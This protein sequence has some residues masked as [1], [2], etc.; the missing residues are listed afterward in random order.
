[1]TA[2]WTLAKMRILYLHQYFSTRAGTVGTRSYEFASHLVRNGHRVSMVTG[3]SERSRI[4]DWAENSRGLINRGTVDGIGVVVVNVRYSNQMS[5]PRRMASFIM[6]MLLSM[7]AGLR[8]GR[9]DLVFATSTPLTIGIP[10]YIL[11]RL[12]RVPFVFEIRDLWPAAPIALG[13]ITNSVLIRL[14]ERLERFLY[15]SA[16][17]VI[18]LS[19]DA[20]DVLVR[21]G[22]SEEKLQFI[23][24]CSD[25]DLFTPHMESDFRSQ[26]NLDDRF[27]CLYTGAMGVANGLDII[28]STADLLRDDGVVFVMVGEGREK[29]RLVSVKERLRLDNVLF[30]DPRPRSQMPHVVAAADLCLLTFKPLKILETTSPNKLFDY[31]AAG[32]PVLTNLGGWI[33][34][35][36]QDS[37][38]GVAV[39]TGGASEIAE[40]ILWLNDNRDVLHQMGAH[41]RQLA[42]ERFDRARLASQFEQALLQTVSANRS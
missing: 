42:V 35:L 14:A 24:N 38:A 9:V 4:G 19:P 22:V 13:A 15:D 33:G 25:L 20:T 16:S 18:V 26:N 2:C 37:G 5:Y 32:K 39:G 31:L 3:L 30:L 28:M 11:S 41:A 10:G 8:A 17:R 40:R 34:E 7:W 12:R 36:L 6:F 23:P 27:V 1:M 21:D 29:R